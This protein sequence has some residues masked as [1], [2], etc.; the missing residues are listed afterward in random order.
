[1]LRR[2]LAVALP[3]LLVAL[4]TACGSS[5]PTAASSP[6]TPAAV[7]PTA[8]APALVTPTSVSV[9]AANSQ[10]R[11]MVSGAKP[12]LLPTTISSTWS[13]RVTE[14]GTWFF[15]V[16]YTSPDETQTVEFAIV[17]PNPPPPGVNGSQAHSNFHGDVH[18]LYQVSDKTQATSER[19]LMWN[20]PG[21]W[22]QPNGIPGV[23][24]LLTT[25][26]L[27]DTQF[28]AVANSLK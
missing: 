23:P 9:A 4:A 1:M 28:W 12:V 18:S 26:G 25:N 17:V 19:F 14:L 11:A 7:T 10:V 3:T 13:A 6:S 24:Y 16:I 5:T 15:D 21:T 2:A 8:S 20:E 27:T 22:T